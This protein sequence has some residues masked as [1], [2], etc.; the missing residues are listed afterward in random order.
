M[1]LQ[2]EIKNLPNTFKPQKPVV[3]FGGTGHYGHYIVKSLLEKNVPVRVLSRNAERA[4][5]IVGNKAEIMEGDLIDPS[6]ITK[7]LH[8]A[9]AIVITVTAFHWK[10]IRQVEQ[11]ERDAILLL[12]DMARN[13]GIS[14]VVYI[15]VY[16][17]R[18][19]L[20][21]KHNIDLAIGPIKLE[22]EQ[23]LMASS[24]DDLNWTILGMSPSMEIFFAMIRGD[25][26]MVPGG[27][28]LAG[29]PAVSPVDVGEIT[30]QA[31]LRDDL[32]G[33]R[34][35]VTGP[36]AFTFSQ[37]AARISE[38]TGRSIGFKEIPLWPIRIVATITRP[39]NPYLWQMFQS[40]K[41][42]N[43]FPED[44]V[45][46]LPKDHE[47]LKETFNYASTTLEEEAKRRWG[48]GD[49]ED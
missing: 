42:L 30:A 12:L 47:R 8:G 18:L 31:V 35:R 44:F 41:L 40:I 43:A 7:V 15:S 20:L 28:P 46:D 26:M 6:S 3:V 21:K 17:V 49:A 29:L 5:T 1:S 13:A 34:F 39:F 11:I 25:N 2:N 32:R 19:D 36:E 45:T 14:R 22:I 24:S 37:A 27:G 4:R 16:E 38:A 10:T 33:Q 9:R 48:A 23:T